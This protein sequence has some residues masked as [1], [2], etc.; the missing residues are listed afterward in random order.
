MKTVHWLLLENA[1]RRA[2]LCAAAARRGTWTI[3]RRICPGPRSHGRGSG[4]KCPGGR[5]MGMVE[6]PRPRP[7]RLPN[8]RSE[9]YQYDGSV[10]KSVGRTHEFHTDSLNH[11]TTSGNG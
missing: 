7:L 2:S 10:V 9:S 8:I 6:P 5:S 1:E 4:G 11:R 3:N